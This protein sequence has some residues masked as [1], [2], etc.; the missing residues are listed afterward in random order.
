MGAFCHGLLHHAIMNNKF[1]VLVTYRHMAQIIFDRVI[2]I[3]EC[4]GEE[5]G[6]K[7]IFLFSHDLKKY[8]VLL[9]PYYSRRQLVN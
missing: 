8:N 3:L 4:N 2:F 7:K 1:T 9:G 6:L 5:L